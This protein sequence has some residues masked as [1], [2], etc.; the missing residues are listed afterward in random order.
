MRP[1][2]VRAVLES[3]RIALLNGGVLPA[4]NY[5]LRLV[6][7]DGLYDVHLDGVPVR[8]LLEQ[9]AAL[10]VLALLRDALRMDWTGRGQP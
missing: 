3:Q 4:G 2:T 9:S 7:R 8:S 6:E 1:Y 5:N 10:R